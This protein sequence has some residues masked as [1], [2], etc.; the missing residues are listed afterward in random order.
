VRT[1]D[2]IQCGAGVGRRDREHCC[3]CWA[4]I[5][6]AAAKAACPKCGKQSML[7]PGTG[8]CKVCSRACASCGHPVRRKDAVLCRICTQR[9][10][11]RAAQHP[12]PRCGRP[13]YL[14]E[15]TGWCGPC[16]HPGSPPRPQPPRACAGCGQVRHL[17]ALGLCSRCYQ[18]RPGRAA[19]TA[20]NLITR[21]QDPPGWVGE[22]AGHVAAAY[23]P[24]W[25]VALINSLGRLLADAGSQH[26]H[27]LLERSGL[28]G[29]SR[30]DRALTRVLGDFLAARGLALAADQA[31]ALAAARRQHLVDA[32]PPLL[33]PAAVRFCQHLLHARDRARRAG[34]RPRAD[35]T[36][37]RRLRTLRDM[38]V[39]LTRHG[40]NDWATASA[41]DVE[42]FLARRPADRPTRL[43]ALRHFFTWAKASK[44]VLTDPT[45]GLSARQTRGYQGPTAMLGLQQHLFRRWTGENVHPHE[46]LSGLLTL[47]HGASNQELRS[48][49]TGDIDAA[50][51]S[52]RLG[53]RP[54]PVPLD[55][56]TWATIEQC[57]RYHQE[58]RTANPHLLVTQK[59]KATRLPASEDYAR[60]LLRP[61]GVTPRLLRCTR[62]AS[63]TLSTDPK[64]VSAAFGIHPQAAT[65]YLAD[66]IDDGRL[67]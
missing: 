1:R 13:G 29:T 48:L 39:F 54:Q 32:V 12:C 6:T 43:R 23:S 10:R 28:A 34:T 8:A 7:Q 65:H 22:F 21:L 64:L 63:L 45:R 33:R 18:R 24:S 56:A 50:A 38:A 62:L 55:P 51:H 41:S 53:R 2:C 27:T 20:A 5:T 66:H 16:S 57:L 30:A 4:K 11:R 47:V 31:T 61:A 17:Y 35:K 60:N 25:A 42:A 46:A 67:P 59:T 40:K 44:L 15:E 19:A 14:R 36:I 9:E 52:I 37:E 26:P 58:L 3:Y 49:T